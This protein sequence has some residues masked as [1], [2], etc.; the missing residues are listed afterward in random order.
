M[1]DKMTPREKFWLTRAGAVLLVVLSPFL[2][3]WVF[4]MAGEPFNYAPLRWAGF[5]ILLAGIVWSISLL[6][7]RIAIECPGCKKP[8]SSDEPWLCP[9]PDCKKPAN[10]KTM[11]FSFLGICQSCRKAPTAFSC[12]HYIKENVNCDGLIYLTRD[13]DYR[14]MAQSIMNLEKPEAAEDLDA[15][16]TKLSKKTTVERNKKNLYDAEVERMRAEAQKKT[17]AESLNPKNRPEPKPREVRMREE[18]NRRLAEGVEAHNIARDERARIALEFANDP[19]LR[20]MNETIIDN[21]LDEQ[22]LK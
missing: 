4:P 11:L 2:T 13:K 3:T 7:R 12:Y 15:E 18:L 22:T 21:W 9:Q 10:Y 19:N 17:V 5:S 14:W 1:T 8:I 6:T 20:E 16:A